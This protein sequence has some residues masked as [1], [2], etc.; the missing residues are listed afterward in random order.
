M[1]YFCHAGLVDFAAPILLGGRMIGTMVGGQV[2]SEEPDYAKMRVTARE[3]GVDEE[4]F[5][6]AAR[7]IQIVPKAAIE[8]AT[9]FIF[10]FS[11][12]VSE[13]VYK[14][15]ETIRLSNLAVSQKSD[16]L[17][18]MSHEIR[19][20]MNAVLG[21]DEIRLHLHGPHDAGGRRR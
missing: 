17:A 9:N 18:N 21:M 20:T 8:R 6:A 12:V 11:L 16:F 13:M 10:E 14:T 15:Y 3:L 2:L 1:S 5:I 7:K 19:T 4:G